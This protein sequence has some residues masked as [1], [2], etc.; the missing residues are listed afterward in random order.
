[1]NKRK[2]EEHRARAAELRNKAAGQAT[3]LQESEL[4]DSEAEAEA[5]RKRVE[6]ERAEREAEQAR[7]AQAQEQARHEDRVREA[8]RLDPDVDHRA[9]DYRPGTAST[10]GTTTPTT[11]S[12]GAAPET[13]DGTHRAASGD[14]TDTSGR[15]LRDG[16]GPDD[17]G[18]RGSPTT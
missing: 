17:P 10:P 13:T 5:E 9:D 4:Q 3:G 8:D 16:P 12:T 18:H 6:V 11:T 2:T 15:D 7:Q 14:T 1:M